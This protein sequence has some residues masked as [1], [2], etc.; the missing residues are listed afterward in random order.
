MVPDDEAGGIVL[1]GLTAASL[2][3]SLRVSEGRAEGS[4]IGD[5]INISS[6]RE[7]KRQWCVAV[8]NNVNYRLA[9]HVRLSRLAV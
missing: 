2:P 6:K 3:A 7:G 4:L 8:D 9:L 5:S 1:T